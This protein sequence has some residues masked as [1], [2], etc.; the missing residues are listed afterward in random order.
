MSSQ[1]FG[2][3]R[4][5]PEL[6]GPVPADLVPG[7]ED[8][9]RHPANLLDGPEDLVRPGRG[10]DPRGEV[11]GGQLPLLHLGHDHGGGGEVQQVDVGCDVVRVELTSLSVL[12]DQLQS[13]VLQVS[14][15]Y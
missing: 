11:E 10:I 3:L 15:K 1:I 7:L 9:L 14:D 6:T 5:Y 12:T 4:P 8:R 13:G 2:S